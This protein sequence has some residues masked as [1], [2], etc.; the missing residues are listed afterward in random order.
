MNANANS[1]RIAKARIKPPVP[2]APLQQQPGLANSTPP[3]SNR[4]CRRISIVRFK[5]FMAQHY[6][7]KHNVVKHNDRAPPLFPMF[8]VPPSGGP[9][10]PFR[11]KAALRTRLLTS[12]PRHRFPYQAANDI[13]ALDLLFGPLCFVVN[14]FS[15]IGPNPR[16]FLTGLTGFIRIY[17]IPFVPFV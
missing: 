8:V 3:S 16:S 4:S 11:L 10:Q 12:L 13:L 17:R 1:W 15:F 5:N 2:S 6:A 7:W 9:P 14:C